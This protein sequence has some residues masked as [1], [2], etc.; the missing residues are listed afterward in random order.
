MNG[1]IRYD[2]DVQSPFQ[3]ALQGFQA[4]AGI[5][6]VLDQR[7]AAEQQAIAAKAAAEQA[8]MR[9]QQLQRARDEAFRNPSADNFSRLM[10]LDPKS[11]EAYQRAW[12]T[13]DSAQQRSFVGDLLGWG[14][15]IKS[16]KP[17]IASQ[18]MLARADAMESQA[19]GP[20]PES[21][22]I[23]A[24]AGVVKEMPGLAL[25]NIQG[26]LAANPLGKDAAETLSKFGVE[27]RAAEQAPATLAKLEADAKTAGIK[28]KYAEE[29]AVKDLEKKGWD[30]KALQA[31]IGFKREA[32]RIALIN[33]QISRE[34]N[35]L[36]RDELG[37]KLQEARSALDAKVRER[38]ATAESGAASIDNMLNTIERIKGNKSLDSVLGSIEGLPYYPNAALGT[39]NPFGNGDERAD[40]IALI[41][42][43]GSQAFLAQIPNIKGMGALSNT[44]GDKLQAAFQ[45]LKRSQSEKQFRENLDEAA[46]LL[47]KGREGLSRSTGVPLAKPDTP[48]APGS[49][50]PLDS[51]EKPGGQ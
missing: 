45:N 7:A 22:A 42:T 38:V 49:R 10:S 46:R 30:I 24:H 2:I 16:G 19:G 20:T 27:A 18:Q 5:K 33:A 29:D 48:A 9:E 41:E 44:E 26:L 1:P 15:A 8:A 3:A 50:P 32:N 39:A 28:A 6:D 21:Q 23:R 25:A 13:R 35:Q 34:T 47:K 11:S 51:F 17:D 40:A 14:A 43:L 12:A 36:K 37:L 4:G 31:D